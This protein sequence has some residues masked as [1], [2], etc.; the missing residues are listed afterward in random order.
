MSQSAGLTPEFRRFFTGLRGDNSKNYWDQ[1]A[2]QRPP[3]YGYKY[4]SILVLPNVFGLT[5]GR[6]RNS[7]TP[8]S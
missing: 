2:Q 3:R 8:A 4:L 6:S 5:Y 7:A 1:H